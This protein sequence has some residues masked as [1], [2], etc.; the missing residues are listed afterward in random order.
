MIME[1]RERILEKLR[2]MMCLKESAQSIG[3]E[4]EAAAAAAAITRLLITYNLSE[5]DIPTEERIENPIVAEEI[6]FR[7][8]VS[9]GEWY[10][11]LISVVCHYN[12]C[13][14]LIIST[15]KENGRLSRDKFQIV[16]RKKNVEV[17]LFLVS[18]LSSK[19]YQIGKR[20]YPAYKE[21]CQLRH[22]CA[23]KSLAMY[24][25]SY[26]CGCVSGLNDKFLSEKRQ[27]QLEC[28]ITALAVS[29]KAEIDEFLKDVKI[30]KS[31][32]S[33]QS[34]DSISAGRGYKTGRNIEI[35]KGVYAGDIKENKKI[36]G[37]NN[38]Y[39]RF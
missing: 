27:L 10:S 20:E 24:M 33:K 1:N 3:N 28:D 16:G 22:G 35:N 11:S 37:L 14:L 17:V 32:E 23:P 7:P 6:P 15:R 38:E 4:G 31:R 39:I 26:L 25:R 30:S 2:K 9:S 13:R 18:F 19:F 36:G 5:T 12:M 29:S 21:E 8:E 34:V